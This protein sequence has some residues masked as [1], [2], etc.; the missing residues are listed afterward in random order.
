[1]KIA[2]RV[3]DV[4]SVVVEMKIEMTMG[5]WMSARDGLDNTGAHEELK[6]KIMSMYTAMR[7]VVTGEDAPAP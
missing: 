7:E 4:D 6:S 3:R 2:A 5:E 1:M